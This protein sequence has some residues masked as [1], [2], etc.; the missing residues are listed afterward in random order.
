MR[1]VVFSDVHGNLPA[2]ELML[3]HAGTADGYVCLGDVVNYGPWSNE[4][5]DL[6]DTLPG[7]VFVEG[8]HETYFRHGDYPGSSR[9]VRSFFDTCFPEFDRAD[10]I[11][12]LPVSHPLPPFTCQHTLDG[13]YVYADSAVVLDRNYLIGHTHR[14]FTIVDPPYVLHN[15]GSVGQNREYLDVVNY[16]VV[17]VETS[18][19]EP[20][21]MTYDPAVV[22]QEM[23]RRRYPQICV[24]YYSR[25]PRYRQ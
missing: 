16:L 23:R 6:I 11:A 2:L 1:V 8:N 22:I 19:V 15:A 20:R 7:L 25:K 4:C 10:A 21:A 24:D 5:L 17:D 13:E 9:L 14:Q 18:A 3:R 12:D